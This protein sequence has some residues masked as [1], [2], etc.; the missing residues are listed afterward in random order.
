MTAYSIVA[1]NDVSNAKMNASIN[2]VAFIVSMQI[3]FTEQ[4]INPTQNPMHF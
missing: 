2:V 3:I 1:A 4:K